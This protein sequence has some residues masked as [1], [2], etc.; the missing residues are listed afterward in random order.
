MFNGIFIFFKLYY[1]CVVD[2]DQCHSRD[3]TFVLKKADTSFKTL[4]VTTLAPVHVSVLLYFS[5]YNGTAS[6]WPRCNW[7]QATHNMWTI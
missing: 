4:F 7:P 2:I 1:A 6:V 5:D 3:Y